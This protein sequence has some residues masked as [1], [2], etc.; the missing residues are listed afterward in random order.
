MA[1]RRGAQWAAAM[2]S[3]TRSAAR[4]SLVVALAGGEEERWCSAED[5]RPHGYGAQEVAR[6][7]DGHAQGVIDDA[8]N[9][10]A[11]AGSRRHSRAT[12]KA[13]AARRAG[14]A[15]RRAEREGDAQR[16]SPCLAV[17]RHVSPKL[18]RHRS[19]QLPLDTVIAEHLTLTLARP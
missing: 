19:S 2:Q 5:S 13:A 18:S 11:K 16:L 1:R 10:Q 9:G 14:R 15:A 3:L 4:R 6:G 12:Q 8:C 17:S 7:D